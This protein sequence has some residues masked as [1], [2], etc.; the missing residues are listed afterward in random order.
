MLMVSHRPSPS[1]ALAR[2]TANDPPAQGT[3]GLSRASERWTLHRWRATHAVSETVSE[4]AFVITAIGLTVLLIALLVDPRGPVRAW[5]RT[6][7]LPVATISSVQLSSNPNGAPTTAGWNLSN[8]ADT[9][10]T[11]TI[12]GTSAMQW[13][14]GATGY[15]W[16]WEYVGVANHAT[17]RFT[18]EL[19]GSGTAWLNVWNGSANVP[20]PPVFLSGVWQTETLVETIHESPGNPSPP[21]IQ[22]G[23]TSPGTLVDVQQATVVPY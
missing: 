11:V 15:N 16:I 12:A 22:I 6:A 10:R 2:M 1:P 19:A 21:E 3:S 20:G 4:G 7:V 17:Y 9:L 5:L 18:V 13:N 23:S 8:G 14:N